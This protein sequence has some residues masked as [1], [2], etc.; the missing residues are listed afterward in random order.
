M[1][2]PASDKVKILGKAWIHSEI[3]CQRNPA[4]SEHPGYGWLVVDLQ[5][6]THFVPILYL[7]S[8]QKG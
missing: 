3:N 7:P 2:T 6:G 8:K 5:K 4:H 1:M